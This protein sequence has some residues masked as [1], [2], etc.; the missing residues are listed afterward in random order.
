MNGFVWKIWKGQYNKWQIESLV[1]WYYYSIPFMPIK[2]YEEIVSNS[3]VFCTKLTWFDSLVIKPQSQM[4][5]AQQKTG[6]AYYACPKAV[7]FGVLYLLAQTK[8]DQSRW[9]IAVLMFKAVEWQ[10]TDITFFVVYFQF[11]TRTWNTDSFTAC[12]NWDDETKSLCRNCV[13]ITMDHS[14]EKQVG[15]RV[16]GILNLYLR[17]DSPKDVVIGALTS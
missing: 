11:P 12:S 10:Q 1:L 5:K 17:Y 9:L 2:Y 4:S 8:G 16:P 13:E 14:F 6:Y 7:F 15:F 3:L